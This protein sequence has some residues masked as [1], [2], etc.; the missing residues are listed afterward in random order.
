MS[1]S[2]QKTDIY[3]KILAKRELAVAFSKLENKCKELLQQISQQLPENSLF[4]IK[5]QVSEE[6]NK[7]K[8]LSA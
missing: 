3:K 7:L 5:K 2:L 1:Q 4:E 6:I 8:E